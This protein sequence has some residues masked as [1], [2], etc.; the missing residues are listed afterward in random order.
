MKIKYTINNKWTY[1]PSK[2]SFCTAKE[3]RNQMI[4]GGWWQGCCE[5]FAPNFKRNTKFILFYCPNIQIE[6][7]AEFLIKVEKKLNIIKYSSVHAVSHKWENAFCTIKLSPW[8]TKNAARRGFL[9]ILLRCSLSYKGNFNEALYS[10]AY[11]KETKKAVTKFFKGYTRLN[12]R[13]NYN[14]KSFR[15][16]V[17][18]FKNGENLNKLIK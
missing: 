15:G 17:R 4:K 16:W 7:I 10:R 6:N 1:R 2:G 8:W 9:T 12:T 11:T 13:L 5:F 3:Q 18:T 14:P